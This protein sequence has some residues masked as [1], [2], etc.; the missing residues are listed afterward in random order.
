[1]VRDKARTARAGHV[2]AVV[3]RAESLD[4]PPGAFELVA[5][6]NAFHR[7]RHD[8]VAASAVR[9]LQPNGY[10]ALLWSS[11]P[12]TGQTDWQRA[13]SAVL[14]GWR[15]R[16][17]AQARVPAGWEQVRRDRPD[18][19]VLT[20][21]GFRPVGSARFRVPHDWTVD[22]LQGLVYSTSALPRPV[23]GKH[24]EA[25]ERDFRNELDEY[26]SGGRLRETIDFAYE[27][28]RRPA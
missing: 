12:W 28:A 22:A 23:L 9:W 4:A 13:L 3:S 19:V 25:F 18:K 5:I 11:A 21:A 14:A 6:G 1:M 26:A 16:V 24:A 20:A 10:I 7:L 15:N 17:G 27:L 2:R 8:A